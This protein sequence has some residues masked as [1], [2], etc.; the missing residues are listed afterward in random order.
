VVL[1]I[2]RILFTVKPSTLV[3]EEKSNRLKGAFFKDYETVSS[4]QQ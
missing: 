4:T 1:I 3:D 2:L